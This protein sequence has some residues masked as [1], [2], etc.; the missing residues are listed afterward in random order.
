MFISFSI[1]KVIL[2]IKHDKGGVI[3]NFLSYWVNFKS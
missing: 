3:K 1:T 2:K